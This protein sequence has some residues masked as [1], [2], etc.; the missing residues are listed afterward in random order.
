MTDIYTFG[1]P[2]FFMLAIVYGALEMTDIF[3][4]K[5]V[6]AIL[7]AAVAAISITNTVLVEG[8]NFYLPYAAGF[9]IVVFFIRFIQKAFKAEAGKKKD[10][11][12]V[13]IVLG[14]VLI[15]FARQG[16]SFR[17]FL[18][19]GPV[20][21]DNLIIIVAILLMAIMFYAAHSSEAK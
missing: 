11:P 19:K 2:F 21:F 20:S 15:L 7:A 1:I 17:G 3:K 5:G 12:L 10:W 13:I 4:N 18:D 8:I 9:F 6:K 14:L 16:D